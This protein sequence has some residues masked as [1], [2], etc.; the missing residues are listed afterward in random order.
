VWGVD[1]EAST[2]GAG[3]GESKA[4]RGVGGKR[5]ADDETTGVVDGDDDSGGW[6]VA[7]V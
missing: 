3:R 4:E 1:F 7:W 6:I 2:T 5:R